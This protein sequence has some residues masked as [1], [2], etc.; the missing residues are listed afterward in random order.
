MGLYQV[1]LPQVSHT[2]HKAELSISHGHHSSL[3]KNK[4]LVAFL[5]LGYLGHNG[6]NDEGINDA[7]QNAL[8]DHSQDSR[9]AFL[10]HATEA[11]SNGRLGLQGEEE[12]SHET[13]NLG[14]T[15][16]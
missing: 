2:P 9:G 8:Q 16:P 5:W 1:T 3:A 6:T 4:S 11:I 14:E 13:G 12:C 15:R 7:S 10:C